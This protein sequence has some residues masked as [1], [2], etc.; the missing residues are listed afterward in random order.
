M[1]FSSKR[2]SPYTQM[3]L[4]HIGEDGADTPAVLIENATMAN[5]AVNIPEFVNIPPGGLL[6]IDTPAVEAYRRFDRAVELSRSGRHEESI[7]EYR[8]ALELAPEHAE[9]HNNLG[10]ALA[11][12]GKLD[13]A[14]EHYRKALGSDPSLATVHNN[15]GAALAR[16]GKAS[17]AVEEFVLFL[18]S[19][20]DSVEA[21]GNLLRAL[22]QA[23]RAGEAERLLAELSRKHPG[24]APLHNSRG[25]A[26]VWQKQTDEAVAEFKR[27]IELDSKLVEARQNLADALYFNAG[28]T[29]EAILAWREL[30]AIAPDHV[31]ALNNAAMV[32]ATDPDPALR[33]ANESLRFAEHAAQLTGG[34]NPGVLDTLASAYATSGRFPE[35]VSTATR[36]LELAQA[37]GDRQLAAALTAKL[38]FYKAGDAYIRP[39]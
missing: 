26:L 23:G 11:H 12:V 31:P 36:A 17:E 6:G 5:R 22:A 28:R 34:R 30:L 33:N 13:E 29:V 3:Y 1:V 9:A 32:M 38:G 18:D 15:L 21:H 14:I 20:P 27:A 4:T 25:V 37:Q 8:R 24:S 19:S 35:A 2:R 39:R 16:S 10:L 7:G